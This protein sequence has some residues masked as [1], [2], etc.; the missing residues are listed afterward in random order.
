MQGT[1]FRLISNLGK[2]LLCLSSNFPGLQR[3]VASKFLLIKVPDNSASSVP[4][5][6]LTIDVDVDIHVESPR[7]MYRHVGSRD[8]LAEGRSWRDG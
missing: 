8:R 1:P 4:A 7:D 3:F 5:R 2:Q 6:P